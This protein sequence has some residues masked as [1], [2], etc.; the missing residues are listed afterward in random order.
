MNYY[1]QIKNIIEN[2]GVKAV[3]VIPSF[4]Y[5]LHKITLN[6]DYFLYIG[7]NKPFLFCG[8]GKFCIKYKGNYVD[9]NNIIQKF[10]LERYIKSVINNHMTKVF[11]SK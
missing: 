1:N 3:D 7:F 10:K 8:W 11:N 2:V 6:N 9:I 4:G 5:E